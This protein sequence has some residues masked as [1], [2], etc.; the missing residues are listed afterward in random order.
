MHSGGTVGLQ[1]FL[2]HLGNPKSECVVGTGCRNGPTG[3]AHDT[4]QPPVG[5]HEVA[6]GAVAGI[7]RGQHQYLSSALV[8]DVGDQ[9]PQSEGNTVDLEK[10]GAVEHDTLLVCHVMVSVV[11]R[12]TV[13]VCVS[14]SQQ[15]RCRIVVFRRRLGVG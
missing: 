3:Y 6:D 4:Y 2:D 15:A 8:G 11:V 12:I 7:V 13:V 1:L 10:G 9:A 5:P 14:R